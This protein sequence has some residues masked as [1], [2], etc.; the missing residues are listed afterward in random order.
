[1]IVI[2][3]NDDS[4]IVGH[5]WYTCG[6]G[7]ALGSPLRVC[8]RSPSQAQLATMMVVFIVRDRASVYPRVDHVAGPGPACWPYWSL[9]RAVLPGR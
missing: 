6:H 7:R 5:F 1:M 8:C 3:S 9:L 4:S 2:G